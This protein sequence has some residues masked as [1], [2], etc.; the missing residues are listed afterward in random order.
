MFDGLKDKLGRFREDVEETAEA[1]SSG[2][3]GETDENDAPAAGTEAEGAVAV[4]AEDDAE[5][6]AV[7]DGD[8]GDD[9]GEPSD[10]AGTDV[11]A[12]EAAAA[13]REDD[14][15][16]SG[17]GRLKRAAAF[18]TGK[19]IIEEEDLEEPLWNL[20]MALLESDVEMTV[21]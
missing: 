8:S 6:D 18:A 4:S 1:D 5:S 21:A 14:E 15:E 12:D 3:A 11:A 10:D 13:L 2:E 20:E 19:I 17:P 7:G 9:D 16:K